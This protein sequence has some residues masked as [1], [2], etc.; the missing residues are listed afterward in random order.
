MCVERR[1]SLSRVTSV[2]G[3]WRC[4]FCL[5]VVAVERKHV[6]EETDEPR[7]GLKNAWGK[8]K[9]QKTVNGSVVR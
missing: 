7:G 4:A 9:T 5:F 2:S 6:I 3:R 1:E 8:K